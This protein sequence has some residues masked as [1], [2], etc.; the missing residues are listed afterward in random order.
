MA[1]IKQCFTVDELPRVWLRQSQDTGRTSDNLGGKF[2]F[3][4]GTIYSYG[5]HFPIAKIATAPNGEEVIFMTTRSNSMTTN[6]HIRLVQQ[7]IRGSYRRVVYCNDPTGYSL[8]ISNLDAFKREMD[9][10]IAKHNKARKPE[11]YSGEIFNQC[12]LAREYCEVMCLPVPS[13]AAL[14]ED[15]EA[16]APLRA[17]LAVHQ[18]VRA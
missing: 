2:Y 1:R 17:A 14:P 10:A 8:S 7:A 6:R 11:L 5:S 15:I 3:Y 16:G 13:W 4:G 18:E 9:A 12:R